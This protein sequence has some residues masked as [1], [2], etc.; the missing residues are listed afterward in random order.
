[1]LSNDNLLIADKGFLCANSYT[2]SGHPV[3]V[4]ARA[5][6][7]ETLSKAAVCTAAETRPVSAALFKS[8]PQAFVCN[9]PSRALSP[10]HQESR[11][12]ALQQHPKA[13]HLHRQ[14]GGAGK[15]QGGMQAGR[16][17]AGL[18][19]KGRGGEWGGCALQRACVFTEVSQLPLPMSSRRGGGG[20][21]DQP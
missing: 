9:V 1:M 14:A 21:L 16:E 12:R 8:N 5:R 13:K 3:W 20:G 6:D 19:H 10:H 15:G 7:K 4:R 17:A 11:I 2:M 18:G